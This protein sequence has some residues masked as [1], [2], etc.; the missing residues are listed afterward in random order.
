L[1]VISGLIMLV[2]P[3]TETYL[4]TMGEVETTVRTLQDVAL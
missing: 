3:L 4:K 1:L 2:Y